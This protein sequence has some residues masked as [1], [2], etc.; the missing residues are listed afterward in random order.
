MSKTAVEQ[1]QT[2]LYFDKNQQQND[3]HQNHIAQS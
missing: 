3:D 2:H 1:R